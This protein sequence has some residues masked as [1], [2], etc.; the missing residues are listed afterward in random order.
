MNSQGTSPLWNIPGQGNM[1]QGLRLML[2]HGYIRP[3]S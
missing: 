3:K 1:T 2:E